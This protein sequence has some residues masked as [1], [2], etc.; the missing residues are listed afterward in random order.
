MH[1]RKPLVKSEDRTFTFQARP[2]LDCDPVRILSEYAKLAGKAERALFA[3]LAK[4]KSVRE[5]KPS[6]M[7]KYGITSRQFNA[8]R[9]QIEGKIAS[10]KELRKDQLIELRKRKDS[11]IAKIQKLEKKNDKALLIHQKK[12]RLARIGSRVKALETEIASGK[13]RLCFGSR[14]L[15]RAQLDLKGN[16]YETQEE[17]RQDWTAARSD[18]FFVLGS[19]DE[20]SGNQS[21]TATLEEDNSISLRL[22]LP[23]AMSQYGKYLNIQKVKFIY[24]HGA[25]ISAL[26]RCNERKLS[27]DKDSGVAISYRF[28]QDK[29]GWVI[30]VSVSIPEPAKITRKGIGVIGVDIN[31]DHLAIV[32]TDRYGNAIARK[33]IPL[34]LYGKNQ[35]QTKALI[36]DAIAKI[37]NWACETK[38]QIIVEQLSFQEKKAELHESSNKKYSRMLSSFAY[39]AILTSI[40]SRAWRFGVMV[41][42]VNPAYTS[43][44]GRVKFA[45]RYGLSIHESAAFCIAR[46]FLRT[47]ER[48]PRQ[49]DQIPDGKGGHVTLSLPVRNRDKHVWTSW[50]LVRKKLSAVHAAHLRAMRNRSPGRQPSACRDTEV[51]D[52]VGETPI[53][54]S[55]TELLGRCIYANTH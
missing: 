39:K 42:E 27:K 5:L 22:R 19:K 28:K 37:V 33:K 41:A 23:D 31:V 1:L 17:W 34:N 50:R 9:V 54:E 26:D 40:K 52:I 12:R 38:K 8:L 44:I 14:K 45:K 13:V 43:I 32:E 2:V 3:D 35:N 55:S 20:S 29:K 53:R 47:S 51:P 4:G 36:G 16:G 21:C 46:R 49:K 24:G 30:F 18:S 6:Y 48:L 11:L 10:I 7:R 15:F 25:I